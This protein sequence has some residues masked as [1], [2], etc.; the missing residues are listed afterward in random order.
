MEHHIYLT[1]LST[2]YTE[3]N[4]YNP[5][6][7]KKTVV[8]LSEIAPFDSIL[9]TNES[10]LKYLLHTKRKKSSQFK[11]DKLFFFK[12][13]EMENTFKESTI[14]SL[15]VFEDQMRAYIKENKIPI[16]WEP[17]TINYINCGNIDYID[18]LKDSIID[19]S[20]AI[21]EYYKGKPSDDKVILHVDLS[22]GP[23]TAIMLMIAIIR[24]VAFQ[25]IQIGSILY[26][27]VNANN[28]STVRVYEGISI[29]NIYD[30]IT[31]FAEFNQFG[32]VDTLTNY[33][34]TLENPDAQIKKLIASMGDFSEAVRLSSRGMFQTSMEDIHT[35]LTDIETAKKETAIDALEG[36]K[37]FEIEALKLMSNK[38]QNNYKTVLDNKEDDLAYIDWCLA[39]GYLQQALALFAEFVPRAILDS[40]MISLDESIFPTTS[41]NELSA[42]MESFNAINEHT[43]KVIEVVNTR[44]IKINNKIKSLLSKYLSNEFSKESKRIIQQVLQNKKNNITTNIT[45]EDTQYPKLEDQLINDMNQIIL[46]EADKET[47]DY[48]KYKTFTNNNINVP[49]KLLRLI[50]NVGISTKSIMGINDFDKEIR[51]YL[52]DALIQEIKEI[53]ELPNDVVTVN[54]QYEITL[55][56]TNKLFK[57]R[58]AFISIFTNQ[59]N[60]LIYRYLF[61]NCVV[62]QYPID[63]FPNYLYGID[64]L[65]LHPA[66]EN[67]PEKI[68]QI[69]R[70]LN[71]YRTLKGSR[72]DTAHAREEKRGQF[73][74]SEDIKRELTQCLND[75]RDIR[76]Y[77]RPYNQE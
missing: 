65:T 29:Y 57:V 43:A 37:N 58:D 34:N 63:R 6:K 4:P 30:M 53:K 51:R 10:A 52:T 72:N 3:N 15:S 66:L 16:P 13:P 75:I 55:N 1:F 25:G 20:Q 26:A 59:N 41:D 22:G 50:S 17:G 11:L 18:N 60:D 21:M 46:N 44:A 45:R 69:A 5:Q 54:D 48:L 23:R 47:Y 24:L 76:E 32:S 19:M 36:H 42:S 38:I 67:N 14:S 77:I 64:G 35:V 28:N 2:L 27:N 74:K 70:I 71:L 8:N 40:K 68:A 73:I 31:G 39:N 7:L 12:S 61:A 9:Q 33:V 62:Y 56:N 49:S